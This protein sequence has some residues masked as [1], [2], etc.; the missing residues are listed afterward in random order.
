MRIVFFSYK[1]NPLGS[2]I[3]PDEQHL[4]KKTKII[5]ASSPKVVYGEYYGTDISIQTLVDPPKPS[6]ARSK[7]TMAGFVDKIPRSIRQQIRAEEIAGT[8]EVLDWMFIVSL[9]TEIDLNN[10]PRGFEQGLDD[11]AANVNISVN[12]NQIDI[13]LER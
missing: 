13:F 4:F 7:Y 2:L 10:V 5:P 12:Q 6:K 8:P 3:Y 1:E 11:M 9:M